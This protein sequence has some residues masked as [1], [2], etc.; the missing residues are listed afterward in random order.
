[1]KKDI[2]KITILDNEFVAIWYYPDKKIVHHQFHKFL[3]GK[4]L[5][6][7][8]SEGTKALQKYGAHKWLS[9]DRENSAIPKDDQEWSDTNWFPQT[10][11]AGWKYWAIVQPES[12]IGQLNIT[13]IARKRV[14][15]GVI[16]KFFSDPEEAMAWLEGQPDD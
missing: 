12:V 7:A 3:H 4:V 5:R 9:D 15:Q 10:K 11:A 13:R 1:M 6:E 16:T 14:E 2:S 8:L